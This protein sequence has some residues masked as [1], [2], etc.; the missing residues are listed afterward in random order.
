M[1]DVSNAEVAQRLSELFSKYVTFD[2][3]TK[4]ATLDLESFINNVQ[5][6]LAAVRGAVTGAITANYDGADNY[7][8]NSVQ[9]LAAAASAMTQPVNALLQ[10]FLGVEP[11]QLLGDSASLGRV[12]LY[13]LVQWRASQNYDPIGDL[14]T[15]LND[16]NNVSSQDELGQKINQTL[17]YPFIRV[18]GIQTTVDKISNVIDDGNIN[19][20]DNLVLLPALTNALT[21]DA[22]QKFREIINIAVN[23]FRQMLTAEGNDGLPNHIYVAIKGMRFDF[24]PIAIS[25]YITDIDALN[26]DT[27]PAIDASTDTV[28]AASLLII[29]NLDGSDGES[30]FG[31]NGNDIIA[32]GALDSIFGGEGNDLIVIADGD[33]T[34]ETGAVTDPNTGVEYQTVTGSLFVDNH[35]RQ[36]I[37][38]STVGNSTVAGFETGFTVDAQNDV[39]SLFDGDIDDLKVNFVG[40]NLLVR[41]GDANLFIAGAE[42]NDSVRSTTNAPNSTVSAQLLVDDDTLIAVNSGNALE[43]VDGINHYFLNDDATLIADSAGFTVNGINIFSSVGND[44][45]LDNHVIIART[46]QADYETT[47][48]I[49]SLEVNGDSRSYDTRVVA[50]NAV[51]DSL[52]ADNE[53]YL[54]DGA[55]TI[56]N[57]TGSTHFNDVAFNTNGTVTV[58]ISK[59]APIN[60]EY[61]SIHSVTGMKAGDTFSVGTFVGADII[62]RNYAVN[63]TGT[64]IERIDDSDS[65]VVWSGDDVS[66][67]NVMDIYAADVLETKIEGFFQ[68]LKTFISFDGNTV[69]VDGA[70]IRSAISTRLNEMKAQLVNIE[71]PTADDVIALL[72]A[73][74][75]SRFNLTLADVFSQNTI[76][77]LKARLNADIANN[78][79]IVEGLFNS[80]AGGMSAFLYQNIINPIINQLGAQI[81]A[82]DISKIVSD[83]DS[84]SE[85]LMLDT[86]F[87]Q[88]FASE[89]AVNIANKVWADFKTRIETH[90]RA[91]SNSAEHMDVV[92]NG[93]TDTL[94]FGIYIANNGG[95][96]DASNAP[97]GTN[98]IFNALDNTLGTYIVGSPYRDMIF[99]DANDTIYSG[100][101]INDRIVLAS[102]S[103]TINI[104]DTI[105][106]T[107]NGIADAF[108]AYIDSTFFDDA[109]T[110]EYVGLSSVSSTKAFGFEVAK[111]SNGGL[112]ID[113][114]NSDVVFLVDGNINDLQYTFDRHELE[115]RNGEG[116]LRLIGQNTVEGADVSSTSNV[117]Y[118]TV[119]ADVLIKDGDQLIRTAFINSDQF[120]SITGAEVY[121]AGENTSLSAH[122]FSTVASG[123]D[124]ILTSEGE[125]VTLKNAA[126]TEGFTLLNVRGHNDS[127]LELEDNDVREL[128]TFPE[129]GGNTVTG[130]KFGFDESSDVLQL[131]RIESL[132]LIQTTIE[133]GALNISVDG[134]NKISIINNELGDSANL[135]VNLSNM[136]LHK[137]TA[138]NANKAI[139]PTGADVYRLN[140]ETTLTGFTGAAVV[141][142]NVIVT[143]GNLDIVV[144][145]NENHDIDWVDDIVGLSAGNTIAIADVDGSNSTNYS[146][147]ADGTSIIRLDT[148]NVVWAGSADELANVDMQDIDY[149]EFYADNLAN[150]I[151]NVI[152]RYVT[153]DGDTLTIDGATLRTNVAARLATA[154]EQLGENA[155]A[156]DVIARLEGI[157]STVFGDE[158]VIGDILNT[159]AIERLKAQFAEWIAA[160]VD[161]FAML[162]AQLDVA[163][164]DDGLL[165][166][167]RG[168]F[169]QTAAAERGIQASAV[170]VTDIY[171]DN[172]NVSLTKQLR[173]VIPSIGSIITSET[174]TE[175]FRRGLDRIARNML[176]RV[177]AE[178]DEDNFINIVLIGSG[179]TSQLGLYFTKLAE[180][181]SDSLKP[182]DA[183][184]STVDNNLIVG[185]IKGSNNETIVG[186]NQRDVIL[187]GDG[188]TVNGGGGNDL[189][190]FA[191]GDVEMTLAQSLTA[192]NFLSSYVEAATFD[193]AHS[194]QV[195]ELDSLSAATVVGFETGWSIDG[196][197]V[198]AINV[199]NINLLTFDFDDNGLIVTG[200]ASSILLATDDD[201]VLPRQ[202]QPHAQF[203]RLCRSARQRRQGYRHQS[204]SDARGGQCRAL[205]PARGCGAHQRQRHRRYR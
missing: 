142:N 161:P 94:D 162:G 186:S 197:A 68:Q 123:N 42:N 163:L 52:N 80:I 78:T 200:G 65:T 18:R 178:N 175:Y 172:G 148:G 106:A 153:F 190:I 19:I 196:G 185:N 74:L 93:S 73:A 26:G 192:A 126:T 166:F 155:A 167:M 11:A 147:S 118:S 203:E 129:E 66:A 56:N 49:H 89:R 107:V 10:N 117:P 47:R 99:A 116:C 22:R 15:Q 124:I 92:V 176:A 85:Q 37:G 44:Y 8:L 97:F 139:A 151:Y 135:L 2:A 130:F 39:L 141:Q 32:A 114:T 87:N 150:T 194:Q 76:D 182:I 51:I 189:I 165:N 132:E 152:S 168:A 53:V 201:A 24:N 100:A 9:E 95:T 17:I 79:D 119:R 177:S 57:F 164:G 16:F 179:G 45:F 121:F 72:D 63:N 31:S 81:S 105:P 13:Y 143:D 30:I 125:T 133:G 113:Y 98:W 1:A 108:A 41:N 134:E 184:T 25:A 109:H 64:A 55:A 102:G 131:P 84:V 21:D 48:I 136:K 191:D 90:L 67:V 61:K 160:G 50:D 4:T 71:N 86:I 38:L 181:G 46:P 187:A 169:V 188:D 27:M 14:L 36:A 110:R 77:N 159:G 12:L 35:T 137:I 54:F 140:N 180:I 156:D 170:E 154:R 157:I 199:D 23:S 111:E 34:V 96:I 171:D 70:G 62:L 6:Q 29:G 88:I 103:G 205:F 83:G 115:L 7:E 112:T 193:D 173:S 60:N 69:N 120:Y 204:R 101:G 149:I 91:D 158:L 5:P 144:R 183:R 128:V 146:V 138:V 127:L 122:D 75:D 3:D 104:N 43:A 40:N 58:E 20:T 59:D 202:Q 198:D 195:V 82:Q 28:S 33:S 174:I 145:Y